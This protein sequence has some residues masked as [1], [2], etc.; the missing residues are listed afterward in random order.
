MNYLYVVGIV[1]IVFLLLNNK[2]LKLHTNDYNGQKI[3]NI[4]DLPS[5]YQDYIPEN[6]FVKPQHKLLRLLNNISA[7]DKIVLLRIVDKDSFTQGTIPVEINN[8]ITDVLK[9]IISSL[10]NVS[11]TDF[12][13][14]NIENIYF[15]KDEFGNLRF[16]VDTFIHDVKNFYTIRLSVDIVIHNG[17]TYIN[18]LDID[19]SAVNNILNKYDVK[20]QAQGILSKYNMF[21]E[22]S[23]SILN[24]Y[25][26]ENYNVIGIKSETSLEYDTNDLSGL[27]SL[28]QLVLNYL[29]AGTS[30]E[31]SPIFCDKNSAQ[32]DKY[33][34][35]KMNEINSDCLA[36]TNNLVREPNTPYDSPGVVTKRVDFNE[37][38]WLKNPQEG[39]IIYSHGFNL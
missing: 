19:E 34:V 18:Y 22:D 20:Y 11:E 17:V 10:N 30:N 25:Y 28:D 21:K 24:S 29:P 39:N 32:F 12:F 26:K 13:I 7:S 6:S 27:F 8:M 4:P 15:M 1:I 23:E 37:Y 5:N 3:V 35:N 2:A 31:N 38:D 14:K 16:I 33:G 36:T 9:T